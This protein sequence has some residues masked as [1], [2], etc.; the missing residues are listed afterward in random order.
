VSNDVNHCMRPRRWI[1]ACAGFGL[2]L[3]LAL[4]AGARELVQ[5]YEVPDPAGRIASTLDSIVEAGIAA[6]GLEPAPLCSDEV[7]IRRVYIDVIGTVPD[8]QEVRRF[9]HD[10]NGA[11]RAL[12]IDQL[13]QREEFADY[14]SLKWCD[15]LRVKSEFPIN[16]WPNAVQ[17][18]HRWVHDAVRANMPYDQFARELLT[19]SGSN[20]RVA[21]VNFYRAVQ[22]REP[23]SIASAVALTFMGTRIQ[24]WPEARRAGMAKFFSRIAYKPTSEWK[25]EIVCLDPRTTSALQALLPDGKSVRIGPDEDPRV[26]FAEW[27]LTRDNPWFARAAANRVWAWLL[28]RGIIHEPDDIRPDNPASNPELLAY[29]EKELV[30]ARYDLRHLYRTILNSRTYQQSSIP[31]RESPDAIPMFACYPVRRLD[32]EVL[33]DALCKITGTGEG[34]QSA[35]PEPFTYVPENQRSIA[36][37][38]GSIGSSFLELFGRPSRDT[39]MESERS[40]GVT[41]GQLL[42]LL[43]ATD[44]QRRI[45]RGWRWRRVIESGGGPDEM[46]RGAYLTVLSRNPTEEETNAIRAHFGRVRRGEMLQAGA[47]L[48]W[49]LMNTKEFLY[50]H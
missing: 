50:R 20:F 47:D 8:A 23:E 31:A 7:F 34:Y 10:R 35:I 42:H 46:I 22:G 48:A 43:N 19:S 45:E 11:K 39:G 15:A 44:I 37:G 13:L 25:E 21:P 32:A 38:D 24:A 14:W 17:A 9:L 29:L 49:A 26:V 4:P 1:A 5:P 12:L 41:E 33:M 2:V 16:L 40:S 30:N 6:K 3:S 36:L 27:L 18:Y 28:G